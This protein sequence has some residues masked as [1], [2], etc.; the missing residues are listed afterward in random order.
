MKKPDI[1]YLGIPNVCFSLTDK[2][3]DREK[4]F[5]KQRKERGFDNSE[6]WNLDFT[7]AKFIV[8]RLKVFI[9]NYEGAV[10]EHDVVKKSKEFLR[11]LEILI[12]EDCCITDDEKHNEFQRGIDHFPD[13]FSA[14]WI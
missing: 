13:I 7:I 2:D 11:S 1:K 9:D 5:A 10:D 8:P 3:D 14:W 6:L 12:E 4:K